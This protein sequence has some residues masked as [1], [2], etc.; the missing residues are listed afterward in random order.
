[1]SHGLAMFHEKPLACTLFELQNLVAALGKTP[2][3]LVVGTQ[4]RDH[5]TYV[6]LKELIQNEEISTLS[7]SMELGKSPTPG[8]WRGSRQESGGGA[9]IDLGIHAVDLVH[10]L[11]GY[12]LN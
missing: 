7:I 11:L 8:S 4:R 1:M 9:L 10:H 6:Y 3:P 12:S 2:V 5:P